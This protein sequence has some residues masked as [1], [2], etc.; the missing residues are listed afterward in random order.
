[1]AAN[2]SSTFAVFCAMRIV[3]MFKLAASQSVLLSSE[4]CGVNI[5]HCQ[6]RNAVL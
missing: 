3:R 1:M 5:M 2:I 6:T 4:G